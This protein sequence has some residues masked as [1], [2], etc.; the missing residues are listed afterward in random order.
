M[1]GHPSRPVQGP[2]WLTLGPARPVDARDCS[3]T[4]VLTLSNCLVE[5]LIKSYLIRKPPCYLHDSE[6]LSSEAST[7]KHCGTSALLL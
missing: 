3:E 1:E 5:Q 6:K 7:K 4:G 2:H